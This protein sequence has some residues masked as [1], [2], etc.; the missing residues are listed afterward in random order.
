M[1]KKKTKQEPK[2]IE[3]DEEDLDNNLK[4]K[5]LVELDIGGSIRVDPKIIK[6]IDEEAK[7]RDI[8]RDD[9]VL[10]IINTGLKK[11][12]YNEE[13]IMRS[14]KEVDDILMLGKKQM[15]LLEFQCAWPKSDSGT[16]ILHVEDIEEERKYHY[17]IDSYYIPE[18]HVKWKQGDVLEMIVIKRDPISD[19]CNTWIEIDGEIQNI[20]L[21]EREI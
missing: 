6:A 7:E 9:M 11:L 19:N 12:F 10:E 3:F 15:S 2:D 17:L 8:S 4:P 1:A 16:A 5:E 21:Q 14:E 18:K 13:G 20:S